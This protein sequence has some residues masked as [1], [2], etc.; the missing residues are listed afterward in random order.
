MNEA[1]SNVDLVA[2]LLSG[3]LG[4]AVPT[5]TE[6]ITHSKAPTWLKSL[7]AFALSAAVAA[8]TTVVVDDHPTVVG[9]L[10][11]VGTTWLA[12]ARAYFAGLVLAL[13][14][15]SGLGAPSP[16]HSAETTE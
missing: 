2:L 15:G 13:A 4:L 6:T 12:S 5:L 11:A 1:I 16:K 8:V 7:L 9:Y 3:V 14:P 10:A